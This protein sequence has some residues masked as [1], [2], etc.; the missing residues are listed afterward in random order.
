MASLISVRSVQSFVLNASSSLQ[1]VE[2]I[3]SYACAT[4]GALVTTVME[5]TCYAM[6]HTH[7]SSLSHIPDNYHMSSCA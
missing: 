1:K 7:S 2:S 5:E 6:K 3:S 4:L